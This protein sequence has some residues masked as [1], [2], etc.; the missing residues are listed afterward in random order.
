MLRIHHWRKNYSKLVRGPNTR[1]LPFWK[2]GRLED[3]TDETELG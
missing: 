2:K 1:N 3:F